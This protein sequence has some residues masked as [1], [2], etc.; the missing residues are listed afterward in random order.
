MEGSPPPFLGNREYRDEVH[1]SVNDPRNS[2]RIGLFGVRGTLRDL[3]GNLSDAFDSQRGAGPGRYQTLRQQ[4]R[5]ADAMA[6][7]TNSPEDYR[8]AVERSTY[9]DPDTGR[10]MYDAM[11]E[12][13]ASQAEIQRR[14]AELVQRS[15]EQENLQADRRWTNYTQLSN[16]ASRMLGAVSDPS[17]LPYALSTIER[18][19]SQAGMS[20][21]DLGLA[22]DMSPEEIAMYASKDMTVNQQRNLPVTEYN[23]E[24]RRISATRPRSAPQPR[25][26]TDSERAI[27]IGNTPANERTV[28]EQQ[29]LDRYQNGVS[30]SRSTGP[31]PR[32]G[33]T[34]SNSSTGSLRIRPVTP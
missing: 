28:G 12:E 11:L 13:Q 21:E 16:L 15:A 18:I 23:A 17:Q 29:W 6:G 9:F 22:S 10:E 3:L 4:E 19:A 24:S 26:T 20:L 25:A 32:P 31:R 34:S 33:A 1:S 14:Q 30:G 5:L 27:Q 8:A 7:F 2:N